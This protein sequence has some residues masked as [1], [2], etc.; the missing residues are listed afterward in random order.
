MTK[1]EAIVTL[2]KITVYP[3]T[4]A[5]QKYKI[6]NLM[7]EIEYCYSSD[8]SNLSKNLENKVLLANTLQL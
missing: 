2:K 7:K 5:D 3:Y 6:S 8:D 1:S 4:S